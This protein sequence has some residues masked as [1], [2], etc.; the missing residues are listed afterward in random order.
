M[1]SPIKAWS[2]NGAEAA[3]CNFVYRKFSLAWTIFWLVA[4]TTISSD[5]SIKLIFILQFFKV[6]I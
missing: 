1:D 4:I 5:L 6:Y 2:S 3:H